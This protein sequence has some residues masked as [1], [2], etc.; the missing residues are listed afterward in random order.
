MG[1]STV[2]TEESQS[3]M[4]RLIPIAALAALTLATAACGGGRRGG[5]VDP[6]QPAFV[7]VQNQS[8]YDM[9]IYIVRSGAR[10][11]LGTVSGNSTVLLEIPHTYVNPGLAIRFMADPIG[12]TRTPYSQ[13]IAVWPGDTIVLRIP[14]G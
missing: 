13:E 9:T 7:E 11:R 4:S 8:W 5:S 12:S 1:Y 3:V 2:P 10:V 6:M 14:P